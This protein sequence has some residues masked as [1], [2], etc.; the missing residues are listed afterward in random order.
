MPRPVKSRMVRMSPQVTY[1][2]PR[3]V[4]MS[5][6]RE[7]VLSIEGL[8]AL[9]LAD[10]EKLDHQTAADMMNVSRP[11]FSRVLALAR[12]TVAEAL[13]NGAALRIEGGSFEIAQRKTGRNQGGRGRGRRR[14]PG[15]D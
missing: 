12:T 6:L 1:Y 7:A 5:G 3:G 13:V 14:N 11:T 10:V 4:P 8:E 15:F 2:K 9:R